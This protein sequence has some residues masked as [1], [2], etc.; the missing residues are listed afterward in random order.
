MKRAPFKEEILPEL[1]AA[2][3]ALAD[4]AARF[5]MARFEVVELCLYQGLTKTRASIEAM[6]RE[7]ARNERASPAYG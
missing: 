7:R 4:R 5:G 2:I 3:D 1:A 6:E